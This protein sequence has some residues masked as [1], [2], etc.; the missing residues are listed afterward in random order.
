[1]LHPQPAQTFISRKDNLGVGLDGVTGVGSSG[2]QPVPHW[3]QWEPVQF[4]TEV[5]M[6]LQPDPCAIP[7]RILCVPGSL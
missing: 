6:A 1:M 7:E 2:S 4:I 5:L 3:D